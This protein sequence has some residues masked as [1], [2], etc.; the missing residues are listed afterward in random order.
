MDAI[1]GDYNI[2]LGQILVLVLQ[3]WSCLG[4]NLYKIFDPSIFYDVIK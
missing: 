1:A 3:L 4:F 2:G